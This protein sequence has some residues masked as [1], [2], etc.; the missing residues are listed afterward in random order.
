MIFNKLNF[1]QSVFRCDDAV[2]WP[3]GQTTFNPMACSQMNF[4][5]RRNILQIQ[6]RRS[7]VI[8]A[9]FLKIGSTEMVMSSVRPS[10]HYVSAGIPPRDF[11]HKSVGVCVSIVRFGILD[12]WP[13][14]PG[15]RP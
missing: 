10:V 8:R 1:S 6:Y 14:N 15:S 3:F 4:R 11:E 5:S 12:P 9:H 7:T 2:K 13:W